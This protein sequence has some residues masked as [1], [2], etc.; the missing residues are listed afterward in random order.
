[1]SKNE[2]ENINENEELIKLQKELKVKYG[3]VIHT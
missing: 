2:E 3:D 1:M